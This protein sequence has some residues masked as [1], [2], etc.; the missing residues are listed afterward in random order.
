MIWLEISFGI[1]LFIIFLWRANVM[2][3]ILKGW[4]KKK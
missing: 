1:L 4:A 3:K 2:T